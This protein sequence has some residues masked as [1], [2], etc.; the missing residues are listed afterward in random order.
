MSVQKPIRFE[1]HGPPAGL[2]ERE[3]IDPS[4]LVAGEPVQRGHDYF[5]DDT[6]QVMAGVWD[7]TPM[8]ERLARCRAS[9]FMPAVAAQ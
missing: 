1:P 8:T 4:T 2:V 9:E 6:G 5:V 7:C 3:K